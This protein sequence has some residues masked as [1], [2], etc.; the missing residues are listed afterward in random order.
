MTRLDAMAT[1]EFPQRGVSA[2]LASP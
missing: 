2:G 1:K